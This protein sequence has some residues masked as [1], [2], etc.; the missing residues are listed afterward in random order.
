[1]MLNFLTLMKLP[2]NIQLPIL[3]NSLITNRPQY[4]QVFQGIVEA[5]QQMLFQI[6]IYSYLGI[7]HISKK[8]ATPYLSIYKNVLLYYLQNK[9]GILK[10]EIFID[11]FPGTI[12][13]IAI[14]FK[15]IKK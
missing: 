7:F 13:L 5:L 14:H 11:Q 9:E 6:S 15:F 12:K 1:M 2:S 3:N 4:A 8:Q 10:E